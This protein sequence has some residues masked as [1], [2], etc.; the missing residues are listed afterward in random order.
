[1]TRFRR[2]PAKLAR[3][4]DGPDDHIRCSS[5][6]Q[7]VVVPIVVKLVWNPGDAANVVQIMFPALAALTALGFVNR[8]GQAGSPPSN[9]TPSTSN[10]EDPPHARRRSPWAIGVAFAIVFAGVVVANL[11][12]GAFLSAN[13]SHGPGESHRHGEPHRPGEVRDLM[14]PSPGLAQERPV[15]RPRYR[16]RGLPESHQRQPETIRVDRHR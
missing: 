16:D 2:T 7:S 6:V 5:A 3:P 10:D 12:T 4:R 15:E 13:G 8:P 1:V 11:V 9:Q 14:A